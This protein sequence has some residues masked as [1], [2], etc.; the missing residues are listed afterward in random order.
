MPGALLQLLSWVEVLYEKGMEVW[1]QC[2]LVEPHKSTRFMRWACNS[3]RLRVESPWWS[4]QD[5][6]SV[7][8]EQSLQA[9]VS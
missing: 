5:S 7:E 2:T 9:E 3:E 4:S 1:L 8:Q 6:R